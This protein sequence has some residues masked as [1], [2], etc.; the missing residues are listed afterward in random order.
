MG[1]RCLLMK[2]ISDLNDAREFEIPGVLRFVEGPG[3]LIEGKVTGRRAA[4]AFFLHGAHVT[5]FQP[6]GEEDVLFVSSKAVY[7]PGKPIRGGVPVILPWFGAH[8]TEDAAPSHGLARSRSWRV[9]TASETPEGGVEV[10]MELD[11]DESEFWPHAFSAQL[12]V[13]FG[14]HLTIELTCTNR[15]QSVLPFE[16][17]LHTYF[18][19]SDVRHITIRGLEEADYL[20]S[21]DGMRRVN[22]GHAPVSFTAET[23]RIY[24][25]TQAECVIEDPGKNRRIRVAKS[26]SDSTV[27]WNPWTTKTPR[28]GDMDLEEW[29]GMVCVETCNVGENAK[30]LG[31]EETRTTTAVIGVEPIGE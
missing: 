10:L 12:R 24:I 11:I 17:A 13:C 8:P 25:D 2:T 26:G 28:L 29:P 30:S 6:A 19:V 5:S 15:S 16:D 18:A 23:D 1:A 21:L 14:T 31:P 3:G 7:A 20:D 22:Q 9:V 27:V 4:G